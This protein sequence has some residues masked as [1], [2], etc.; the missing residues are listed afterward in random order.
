LAVEVSRT[1]L[2]SPLV[3]DLCRIWAATLSAALQGGPKSDLV[4]L[5]AAQA[6]MSRR[7]LKPQITAVLNGDWR[8]G[9]PVDDAISIVASALDIFRLTPTFEGALREAVRLGTTCAALVGTLAGAH[10]GSE[11][12]APEWRG[13]LPDGERLM[14]LATRLAS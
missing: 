4:A 12:I 3:L 8:R 1:T 10:Y 7:Q 13:A 2:Q 14:Q 11:A 5:R 6:V 9:E